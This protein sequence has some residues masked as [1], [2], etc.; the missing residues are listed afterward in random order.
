M[1][2]ESRKVLVICNC[3]ET[4]QRIYEEVKEGLQQEDVEIH[5]FHSHF[6]KCDRTQKEEQIQA[7]GKTYNSNHNINAMHQ[8]WIA[9][10]V[11]EASLDIDFDYLFTELLELF[12]L[13]NGGYIIMAEFST[14]SCSEMRV[15]SPSKVWR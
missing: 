11:V 15:P 6:T 5:L 4:A 2:K 12:S 1:G 14:T 8:I 10:S 13:R 3:I 9:T 7:V